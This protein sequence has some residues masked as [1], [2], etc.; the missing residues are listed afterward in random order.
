[1]T[2]TREPRVEALAD[3]LGHLAPADDVEE[4]RRLL[5]LLGLA[6]LPAAVDRQPEGGGRL[7]GRGESQLGV[8][9][10]VADERDAVVWHR[11]P[12]P[13]AQSPSRRGFGLGDRRSRAAASPGGASLR[14]AR[15]PSR[16]PRQPDRDRRARAAAGSRP[17]ASTPAPTSS[18]EREP[19]TLERALGEPDDPVRSPSSESVS[20]RS[21]RRRVRAPRS[22]STSGS[23]PRSAVLQLVRRSPPSPAI[24]PPGWSR[25]RPHESTMPIAGRRMIVSVERV[26]DDHDFVWPHCGSP[27]LDRACA[28]GPS[29][30]GVGSGPRHGTRSDRHRSSGDVGPTIAGRPGR[31]TGRPSLAGQG[32]RAA[33][34]TRGSL[35]VARERPRARRPRTRHGLGGDRGRRSAYCRTNLGGARLA[36][37]SRSW[38][39]STWPSHAGPAPI[40]IVG[41]SI[42]SVTARRPRRAPLRARSRSS[43]RPR[44]PCASSE[45]GRGVELSALDPEPPIAAP[46]AASGRGGP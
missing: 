37:P 33:P 24:D 28:R 2:I 21:A 46:T 20:I 1:M 4:R 26:E 29:G 25:P 23:T 8:A 16:A 18:G 39:T 22:A 11:R 3:V 6:V 45:R 15:P 31:P 32:R 13:A 30:A 19:A 9:G 7:A 44:A 35:V 36:R 17:A 10:D 34:A 14:R 42:A 12:L 38:N 27:P 41:T 43:P 5:P 40:P